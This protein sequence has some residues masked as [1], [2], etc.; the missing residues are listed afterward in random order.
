MLTFGLNIYPLGKWHL[1]WSN[2]LV[3]TMDWF[4]SAV[5]VEEAVILG[6]MSDFDNFNLKTFCSISKTVRYHVAID[7]TSY[8]IIVHL[9]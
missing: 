1:F 3:A 2:Q 6:A 8:F 9:I 4:I 7:L 5:V